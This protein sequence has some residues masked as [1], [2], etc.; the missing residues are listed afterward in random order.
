MLP[1]HTPQLGKLFI[2]TVPETVPNQMLTNAFC[3]FGDLIMCGYQPGM[4]THTPFL[5]I[6]HSFFFVIVVSNLLFWKNRLINL[7]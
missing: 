7:Q 6:I 4:D 5:D 3:R 1:R 2:V